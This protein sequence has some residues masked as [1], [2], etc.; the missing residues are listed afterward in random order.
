MPDDMMLLV[1]GGGS[2]WPSLWLWHVHWDLHVFDEGYSLLLFLCLLLL[3]KV[4]KGNHVFSGRRSRGR[5][6]SGHLSLLL[7]AAI[8]IVIILTIVGANNNRFLVDRRN[9][10]LGGGVITAIIILVLDLR[11]V[12]VQLLLFLVLKKQ[13]LKHKLVPLLLPL[14]GGAL[15]LHGHFGLQLGGNLCVKF[16]VIDVDL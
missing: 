2:E 4:F 12:L 10:F 5:R 6:G 16:E 1:L 13:G 11:G 8:A 7:V 3:F 14:V 9:H 15:E